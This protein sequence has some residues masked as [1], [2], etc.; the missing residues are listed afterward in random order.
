MDERLTAFGNQLIDSHIRLRELLA[1]LR[2]GTYTGIDLQAHCLAFCSV[3]AQHHE[4]ED[5]GGFPL[6][7]KHYPELRP[8]L[9]ELRR[10]HRQVAEVLDRLKLLSTMDVVAEREL[11]TLA[12]LL[13][14]HLVYE[15]K[16]LV[17]ALNMLRV[18]GEEANAVTRAVKLAEPA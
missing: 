5:D 18:G 10:D 14:T 13:E 6:L 1:A 8:V 4:A 11:D 12:A 2:D 7:G 17:A 3:L 16:K 9:D 15:E